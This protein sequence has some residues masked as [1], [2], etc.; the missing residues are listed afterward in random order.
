MPNHRRV[1][2]ERGSFL[3]A[4]FHYYNRSKYPGRDRLAMIVTCPQFNISFA[5]EL[6]SPNDRHSGLPVILT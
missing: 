4:G 6:N 3:L 2:I 5:T 1:K